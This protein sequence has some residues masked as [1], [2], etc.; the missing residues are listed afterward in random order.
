MAS[1]VR[2][3]VVEDNEDIREGI[4]G[5]LREQGYHVSEAADGERGLSLLRQAKDFDL[6]ILDL[7][8]P[9]MNGATFRWQQRT[10]RAIADVPVLVLSSVVDGSKS[11]ELLGA[12]AYLPKPFEP[13]ALI[14]AVE[15][16]ASSRKKNKR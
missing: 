1:I 15:R 9:V 4:A 11:A 3:L 16:I 13:A 7:R 6:V 8:M 5:L 14:E 10:D 2:I 12:A